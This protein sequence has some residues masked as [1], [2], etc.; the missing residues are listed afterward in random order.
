MTAQLTLPLQLSDDA[1]FANFFTTNTMVVEQIQ[2]ALPT[3]ETLIYLWGEPGSGRSHLLQAICHQ[4]QEQ[5]KSFFYLPFKH[6][7]D[8]S[9]DILEGLENYDLVCLDD[10]NT[11]LPNKNWEE[12]L[13]HFYNKMRDNQHQIVISANLSPKNLDCQLPDLHSRLNWGLTLKI[14]PLCD[15][16]KCAAIELRAKNRGLFISHDAVRYLLTHHA[17]NMPSLFNALEKLDRASLQ[18]KRKLT[19]PFIKYILTENG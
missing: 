3:S 8:L 11:C 7:D 5:K 1:T 14:N 18:M 9:P 19:I 13:F 17:R 10:I 15:E 16:E 2:A 12:A 4:L 6:Y